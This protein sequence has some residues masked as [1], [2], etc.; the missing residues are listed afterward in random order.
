MTAATR[1][2]AERGFAATSIRQIVEASGCTNPSLYYY[3]SSKEDLFRKVVD[4]QLEHIAT[5]LR[6]WGQQ[7]GALRPRLHA[8][9]EAFV[10]FGRHHPESFRLLH[11]LETNAEDSAPAVDMSGARQ[12]H[13]S[14]MGQM[15]SQGIAAGEIRKD[16]DPKHAALA[17]AGIVNFQ[18]QHA[19]CTATWDTEC[20]QH[21]LD[22]LFDGIAA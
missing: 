15:V 12:L 11:R 16:V 9:L 19:L 18:L 7:P 10:D 13:L 3:F 20:I 14:L 21:T 6:D 22:L 17:L 4:T 1:L 5:F 8:A 2:F